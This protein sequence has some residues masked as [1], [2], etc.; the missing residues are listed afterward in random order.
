MSGGLLPNVTDFRIRGKLDGV[1]PD[2]DDDVGP[3]LDCSMLL[4]GLW[5]ALKRRLILC[6]RVSGWLSECFL[7]TN[8]SKSLFE[9]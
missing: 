8:L 5:D 9:P 4:A 2:D 6:Q 1:I 7:L 3:A